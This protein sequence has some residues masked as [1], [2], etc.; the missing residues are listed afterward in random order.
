MLG[1]DELLTET[2]SY[3]EYNGVNQ[4]NEKSYKT[5]KQVKCFTSF[6]FSNELGYDQQEVKL[7]KI[8]FIGKDFEPNPYDKIDGLEIR[9]ITP[10]KGLIVP[11]IG[12]KIIL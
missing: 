2:C 7:N 11:T 5:A 10:V 12:Y 1:Y 4:Y 8:V 3:E 6:D 9:G